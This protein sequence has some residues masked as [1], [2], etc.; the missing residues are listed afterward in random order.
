MQSKLVE[1]WLTSCKELSFTA[2]SSPHF[3]HHCVFDLCF[4]LSLAEPS[5]V[6]RWVHV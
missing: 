1:N 3:Q 5:G 4:T 2:L 6:S